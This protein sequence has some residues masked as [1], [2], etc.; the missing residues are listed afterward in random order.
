MTERV[1]ILVSSVS[2][3]QIQIVES[4]RLEDLMVSKRLEFDKIDGALAENKEIRDKLFGISGLRGKYPQCFISSGDEYRFVGQWEV[5]ESL[6]DCDALPSE[7]LASNPT[8]PTFSKVFANVA[9]RSG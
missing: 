7:T 8:I 2:T 9:T 5:V 6:V 4:R 3:D 1:V